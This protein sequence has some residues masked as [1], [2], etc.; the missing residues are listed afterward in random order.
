[1]QLT[2]MAGLRKTSRDGNGTTKP[3]SILQLV[4]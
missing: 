1:M 3:W 4:D 2:T